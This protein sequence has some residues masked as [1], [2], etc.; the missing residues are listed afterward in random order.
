MEPALSLGCILHELAEARQEVVGHR[1]DVS[2]VVELTHQ[3]FKI[4]PRTGGAGNNVVDRIVLGFVFVLWQ[5]Y[6]ETP[7]I[8]HPSEDNLP[9][10]W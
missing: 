5:G 1:D 10:C 6:D 3:C 8:E 2:C 9:F 7:G 4:V